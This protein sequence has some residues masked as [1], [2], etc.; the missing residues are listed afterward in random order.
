MAGNQNFLTFF[1]SLVMEL[2][3]SQFWVRVAWAKPVLQE[4]LFIIQTLLQDIS[5]I[6]S[7]LHV[8][9]Q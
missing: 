5:N 9:L 8:T 3:G 7:L 2:P 4:L 6:G 1:S